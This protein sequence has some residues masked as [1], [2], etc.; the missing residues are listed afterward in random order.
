M[1]NIKAAILLVLSLIIGAFL[2]V[3]GLV[4]GCALFVAIA[5]KMRLSPARKQSEEDGHTYDAEYR[6]IN[7]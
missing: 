6:V 5:I 2:T 4:V 7:D 3:V 1:K